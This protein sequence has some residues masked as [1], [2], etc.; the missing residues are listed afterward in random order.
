M[1]DTLRRA[2]KLQKERGS[3]YRT[4]RLEVVSSKE[5]EQVMVNEKKDG[6]FLTI[7]RLYG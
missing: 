6:E 1:K 2:L 7:L 3:R 4:Y 5:E